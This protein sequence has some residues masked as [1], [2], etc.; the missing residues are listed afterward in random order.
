MTEVRGGI[1]PKILSTLVMAIMRVT[2]GNSRLLNRLLAQVERIK[3]L[4]GLGTVTR[5]VVEAA[6][7]C[8]A[9]GTA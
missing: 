5:E 8:L 7:E 9:I 2:G 6:R 1:G 3:R 4:N